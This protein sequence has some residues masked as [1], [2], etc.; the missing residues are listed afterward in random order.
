MDTI[1]QAID[2]VCDQGCEGQ[3]EVGSTPACPA[4]QVFSSEAIQANHAGQHAANAQQ[5][6]QCSVCQGIQHQHE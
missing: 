6:S 2:E 4:I 5:A 1:K 3:V